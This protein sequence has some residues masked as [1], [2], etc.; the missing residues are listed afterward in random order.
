MIDTVDQATRSRNM[1]AIKSRNTTPELLIRSIL[2]KK[3]FRF[4]LHDKKLPGKPDIVFPKYNAVIFIN[5]CFWHGHSNCKFFRL[6]G[7]RTEY[8]K[9][10]INKNQYNDAKSIELLLANNWRVCIIWEC[11]I[12][13]SKKNLTQ[14]TEILSNFLKGKESFLELRDV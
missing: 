9:N 6:P 1:A 5:G 4:R 10:K 12:R 7:T 13:A 11:K 3:G 14:L 8:W 2:H